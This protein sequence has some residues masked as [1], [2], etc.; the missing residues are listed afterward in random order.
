MVRFPATGVDPGPEMGM[1]PSGHLGGLID[2][3]TT[4]CPAQVNN[5]GCLAIN[6]DYLDQL[7][8]PGTRAVNTGWVFFDHPD[9]KQSYTHQLTFGYERELTPVLSASVDFVSMHGRDR[10]MLMEAR[11]QVRDGMLRADPV[12]RMDALGLVPGLNDVLMSGDSYEG[13]RVSFVQNLGTSKYQALNF[14]WRS[15]TATTG[16]CGRSTPWASRRAT[17]YYLDAN[18]AQVGNDLNI[19]QLWGPSRYDRRHNVTLSGR[20]EIPVF[21]GVT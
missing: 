20:T 21:G 3:S 5:G 11:P 6:R 17:P 2:T 12:T 16:R 10:Q 13:G 4:G 14:Q 9:R 1:R 18:W 15:A 19:D 7:F 8:P